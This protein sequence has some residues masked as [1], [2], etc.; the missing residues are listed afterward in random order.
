M[1]QQ[2]SR[3][4]TVVFTWLVIFLVVGLHTPAGYAQ[5]SVI[6]VGAGSNVP[7]QLYNRWAEEYN[8]LGKK[9]SFK[10]MA[11]GTNEGLADTKQGKSDFGVGEI[12][13][14]PEERSKDRLVLL[15]SVLVGIAV[16]YNLPGISEQIRLSGPVLAEI[17]LGNIKKWNESGIKQLNAGVSLPDLP[18]K[19]FYR[20]AGKGSN[21]IFT[22]FLSKTSAKFRERIGVSVSP[23]WPVGSPADRS[24]EVADSVKAQPGAIGFV[25]LQ[26]AVKGDVQYAK[27]LNPAG[28]YV[29]PSAETISA[30][31]RAV[32][33]PQWDKFATSLANAPGADSYPIVSFS[34]LYLPVHLSDPRHGAALDDLFTWM[35]GDGQ[36]SALKEGYPAL[37]QPLLTTLKSKGIARWLHP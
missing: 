36:A 15:P 22:D 10:Y 12:L 3:L 19:V 8:K 1:V 21:R 32:E 4:G 20:P 33:E 30:A 11:I 13:L 28:N 29:R 23:A 2:N 18:I 27:V 5:D 9:T 14:T 26:Y 34:W 31:C 16:V 6:L 7:A 37:P 25:E 17:Y 24:A 35:F